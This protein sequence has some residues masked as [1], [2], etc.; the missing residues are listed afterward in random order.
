MATK[1]APAKK[2]PVKKVPVKK[3]KP[4]AKKKAPK[5]VSHPLKVWGTGNRSGHED[6]DKL[7]VMAYICDRLASSSMSLTKILAAGYNG[8]SLPAYS[9]ITEWLSADDGLAA[10]YARAKEDQADYLAEDILDIADAEPLT[11]GETGKIDPAWVQVQKLR[12]DARKWA[13]S[14]LKPKKYSERHMISG[15]ADGDPIAHNHSIQVSFVK[16]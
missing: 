14:K 16:P 1:K 5:P 7:K 11:D 3:A 15:D 10:K 6:W 12:V 9:A 8:H 4:A 13:A 2:A